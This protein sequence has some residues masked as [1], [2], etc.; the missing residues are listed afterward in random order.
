[1][2]RILITGGS[3]GIGSAVA[4][5]CASRALW[6]VVSYAQNCAAALATV[7]ACGQGDAVRLDLLEEDW[8]LDAIGAVDS[9]VHCAGLYTRQRSLLGADPR[10]T[11]R[12]LQVNA[13]GPLR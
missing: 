9:V 2:R 1:M 4:R 3:G 12:L 6:P 10:E 8:N 11:W 13:L 5:V 7:A